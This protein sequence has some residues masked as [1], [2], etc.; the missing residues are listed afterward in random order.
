MP[1][2]YVKWN[3]FGGVVCSPTVPPLEHAWYRRPLPETKAC[4]AAGGA[5]RP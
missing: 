1:Y 2:L 4:D 3:S 5:F